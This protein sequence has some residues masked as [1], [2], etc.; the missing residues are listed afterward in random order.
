MFLASLLV[1]LFGIFNGAQS[2]PVADRKYGGGYHAR[3]YG[4]N[5][6]RPSHSGSSFH[7][8]GAFQGSYHRPSYGNSYKQRW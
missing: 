8:S 7:G 1:C 3:P 4:S 2:N 6:G 5:Y